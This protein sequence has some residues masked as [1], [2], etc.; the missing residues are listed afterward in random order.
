MV[1]S[2]PH[3]ASRDRPKEQAKASILAALS[4]AAGRQVP[5]QRVLA[6]RQRQGE[7]EP[8]LNGTSI[9]PQEPW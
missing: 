4:V 6:S 9:L 8:Q 2:D 3:S 7:K 5:S 1:R